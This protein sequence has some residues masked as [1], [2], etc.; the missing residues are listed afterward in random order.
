MIIRIL[1]LSLVLVLVPFSS[2][3]ANTTG[4]TCSL[5]ADKTVVSPG[6][7][8]VISWKSSKSI[9][10]FG[11]DNVKISPFGSMEVTPTKRT[12]YKFKFVGIGGNEKCGIRIRMQGEQVPA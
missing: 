9:V 4:I 2:H 6:E 3:A 11:P 1:A 12:I 8:V 5:S 10:S 7:K